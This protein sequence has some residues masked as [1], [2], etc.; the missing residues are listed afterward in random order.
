MKSKKHILILDDD[1][2]IINFMVKVFE[3][4]GYG[5][6]YAT[7]TDNFFEQIKTIGPHLL[8]ID[9]KLG[10]G[11]QDGLHVIQNLKKDPHYKNIP[12]FL[13][14]ASTSRQLVT[15]ATQLGAEEFIK[16]PLQVNVLLQ[17]VKKSL[18]VYELPTIEFSE[19][20]KVKCRS[21][22]EI[23]QIGEAALKIKGPIKFCE[24]VELLIR[25]PCLDKL[26]CQACRYKTNPYQRVVGPGEYV[27]E[28]AMKGVKEE[29]ARKIRLIKATTKS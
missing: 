2:D 5:A 24:G 6:H 8:I 27:N 18:K 22:G 15:L 26:G 9:H 28:I 1:L 20:K 29:T 10:H 21:E 16:K 4:V 19:T 23:I 13:I 7:D 3:N 11:N 17:K 12:T 25:S 14:S